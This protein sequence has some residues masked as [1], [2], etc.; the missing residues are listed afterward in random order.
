MATSTSGPSSNEEAEIIFHALPKTQQGNKPG[1]LLVYGNPQTATHLIIM[2]A[3]YPDNQQAFSPMANRLAAAS[4]VGCLIGITCPPGYDDVLELKEYPKNGFTFDDW[5][6]TLREAIK[7]LRRYSQI[8]IGQ[9]TLTGIFHDWGVIMGCMYANRLAEEQNHDT[10]GLKLDR[11]IIFDVLMPPHRRCEDWDR[12]QRYENKSLWSKLSQMSY[13]VFLAGA[14]LC[15]RYFPQY[16]SLLYYMI[17]TACLQLL[18]MYPVSQADKDYIQK[19][20][21][22]NKMKELQRLWY[23]AYPY[24]QFWSLI[25]TGHLRDLLQQISL[26]KDLVETPVLYLY[27]A[28][29]PYD[30]SD[31]NG[32]ELL[33]QQQQAV[34]RHSRVVEV[35]NAGH[36]LY[37]QQPDI[38]YNAMQEFFQATV[39][40]RRGGQ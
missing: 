9:T 5:V 8:P 34:G 1:R 10:S 28:S 11:M 4:G 7:A 35:E 32:V 18:G 25:F 13:Q 19:S 16:L 30:L 23:M 40:P 2:S 27:G 24:Y 39:S 20:L 21:N 14:F 36:W 6:A 12:M 15:N 17:G 33:K 3:G 31:A 29:K 26:P 38:C 37:I 22:T